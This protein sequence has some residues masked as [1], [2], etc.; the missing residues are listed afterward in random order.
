MKFQYFPVF[1][2]FYQSF[3]IQ[4]AQDFVR[5]YPDAGHGG[6]LGAINPER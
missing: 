1:I 5:D 3:I 6:I 4:P 2:D